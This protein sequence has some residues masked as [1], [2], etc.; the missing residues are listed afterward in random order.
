MPV[1]AS[2]P[3]RHARC[4]VLVTSRDGLC[5]QHR[6]A[7]HR[8]HKQDVTVDYAERNRFYQRK[9]WKDLRAWRLLVEP[10][11][12]EC[13][14]AGRLV[15]ASVVDHIIPFNSPIDARALDRDNT[16]SL[17]VSCHS[18][19]TRRDRSRGGVKV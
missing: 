8:Q 2:R 15:E 10:L 17:C 12:R 5:D 9:V 11:C 18:A 3:C 13:R 16:Q 4:R 19:K 1:A 7:A 14:K 6:A